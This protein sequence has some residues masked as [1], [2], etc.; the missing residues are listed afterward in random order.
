MTSSPLT[1]L[2]FASLLAFGLARSADAGWTF[3]FTVHNESS[4]NYS[5]RGRAFVEGDSVRYDVVEGN[6]VLFNPNVSVISRQ[7]GKTLIVL[8]HRMKTYF[9]RDART[10]AGPVSTWRAPGQEDTS[11]VSLKVT[12]DDT[13]KGDIAGHP[14][15]KYDLKASYT[16][17]MKVADEK[18][19]AHVEGDAVVWVIEM[20]DESMPFGLAFALKSG[21]ADV[22]A[23]IA[24]RIGEKG[25]P[26]RGRLAVT[27]TIGTGDAI[28]ESIAFDVDHIEEAK[29][30]DSLF[31]APASY[32][33]R[34]PT[35]GYASP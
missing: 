14:A 24:K 6:H 34:E 29:H 30:P 21:V 26:V 7:G 16:I 22:D 28:T 1:R 27:R 10:M 5:Y 25:F 4:A 23:Q 2:F 31:T 18:L 19:K 33:W 12:K 35:F 13:A 17:A 3:D 9:L 20:K 15:V 11:G 8:D 32:S